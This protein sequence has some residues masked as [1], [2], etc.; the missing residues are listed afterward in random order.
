MSKM[1]NPAWHSVCKWLHRLIHPYIRSWIQ[2]L[3]RRTETNNDYENA[4]LKPTSFQFEAKQRLSIDQFKVLITNS[5]F[6]CWNCDFGYD[7]IT[8]Y[9][10]WSWLIIYESLLTV[11]KRIHLHSDSERKQMEIQ[12]KFNNVMSCSFQTSSEIFRLSQP[13]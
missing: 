8:V 10:S 9:F 11:H 2:Q 5:I 4:S 13:I 1:D 6:S 12:W 7:K 3:M